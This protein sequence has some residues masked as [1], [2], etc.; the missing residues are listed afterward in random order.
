MTVV[1]KIGAYEK[2][3]GCRILENLWKS[4]YLINLLLVKLFSRGLIGESFV[5]SL[6]FGRFV[7]CL[8]FV[9]ASDFL[10]GFLVSGSGDSTVSNCNM[11]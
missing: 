8:A 1:W 3:Q 2:H 6:S 10:T 5:F 9:C 4:Q 11:V 7:S